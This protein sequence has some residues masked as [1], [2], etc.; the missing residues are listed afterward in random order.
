MYI[1]FGRNKPKTNQVNSIIDIKKIMDE[2][3]GRYWTDEQMEWL[4]WKLHELI[5]SGAIK[6][7]NGKLITNDKEIPIW[8]LIQ[9]CGLSGRGFGNGWIHGQ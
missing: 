7:E 5:Q 2:I 4:I 1:S 8:N 3:Q 9:M 6:I